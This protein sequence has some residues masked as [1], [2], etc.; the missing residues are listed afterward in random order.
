M[1][2]DMAT[3]WPRLKMLHLGYMG[4]IGKGKCTF[5][6]LVCLLQRCLDLE[7]L[8]IVI[9][10]SAIDCSLDILSE[11]KSNDKLTRIDLRD[12]KIDDPHTIAIYLSDLIP[13]LL[14]SNG[15]AEGWHEVPDLVKTLSIVRQH[16]R[17]RLEAAS[18]L[19]SPA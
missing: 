7:S 13:N 1:L 6:G 16:E 14:V 3:A 15:W 19:G 11:G 12:S 10:A 17:R 5:T 8:S 2:E 9:D 18:Q 4:G